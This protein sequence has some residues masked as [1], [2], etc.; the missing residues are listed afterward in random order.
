MQNC[1][2][3]YVHKRYYMEYTINIVQKDCDIREIAQRK[4]RVINA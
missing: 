3:E 2:I 1:A 4:E